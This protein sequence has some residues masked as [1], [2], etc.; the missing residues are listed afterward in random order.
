[1]TTFS[2]RGKIRGHGRSL[3]RR[4]RLSKLAL[5]SERISAAFWPAFTVTCLFLALAF[6]GLFELAGPLAHRM[7]LGAFGVFLLAALAYG[8]WRFRRPSQIEAMDRLDADHP[9]RPLATM[10]DSLVLHRSDT[11]NAETEAIWHAHQR[12]AQKAALTLEAAAPD[13]RLSRN[14]RWAMRLFAPALLLAAL[15]GANQ[16][17]RGH[18]M[19]AFSPAPLSPS[20]ATAAELEPM[21]E[22]WATPPAYT[23]HDTLYLTAESDG[24]PIYLAT[25]SEITVR[26]TQFDN[27]PVLDA[28]GLT[29][30]ADFTSLGGGLSEVV[31]ELNAS[32]A[33]RVFDGPKLMA[34]W[35]V[36]AI[37]DQVPVIETTSRPA[38]T[39]TRALEIEFSASDD[40]GVVSAWAEIQPVEADRGKGLDLEP[41][42]FALPLPISRDTRT[43]ADSIIEDLTEHPWAG[44]MVDLVLY[45]EDGA[46]QIGSTETIS[47]RLPA[48]YFSD[49]LAA[50][51]IEQRRDLALDFA[52][53][54]RVLDVIQAITKRPQA[55]F[56]DRHGPYMGT[57]MAVR[58]LANGIANETV[59]AVAPE[60]VDLLWE[61]ALSLEQGDISDALERLRNAEQA[62]R[63]A[64]ENGTDEEVAQ[65]IQEL[66][67]AMNEYIQELARQAQENPQAFQ[68]QQPQQ[69]G[70]QLSQQD[71][72]EMLNEMQ[73]QAE[74]GLRD[75]ARDML[76]ELSRMLENL[77]AGQ[78]QMQ[79][80]GQGQ[81]AMQELQEMIQRQRDLADR[82]FDELRQQRR[83]QQ[84][85]GQGNRA[86]QGQQEGQRPGEGQQGQAPGQGRQQGGAGQEGSLS[87][88]QEALRRALEDLARSL[89]G[90][91]GAQR[92]LGEAGDAMGSARDALGDGENADAVQDQM[93]ALDR[94]NEGAQALADQMQNGQGD[95][96]AQ[97]R[98]EQDG[99]GRDRAETDPFDRPLGS[100]GSTSGNHTKVPDRSALDRAREILDELRRRSAESFRPDY[101]LDYFDRLLD[102]F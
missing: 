79:Q 36:E 56:E 101:E 31:A 45:A 93:E 92:A 4:I 44:S 11:K 63:D 82:T 3:R 97:G 58:R 54:A 70:Q 60:I 78:P 95:V 27:Q 65:A 12:Q 13:L 55:I 18:L 42:T 14:D 15:V 71:L 21:V 48:R 39:L 98:G 96:G 17:W 32:G 26:T 7:F 85:Q 37:P 91:E 74:S 88:Q 46:G 50:A 25:G 35:H 29:D 67:E 6:M 102:Q 87:A 94:M 22:A 28:P 34:E 19:S 10:S 62:L 43:I 9:A 77:Q 90:G 49:P 69:Q 81:Q 84:G 20:I 24:E 76:S 38:P 52:Q 53:A 68:E 86:E 61:I 72:D 51:L 73:R 16:D 66:R 2:F 8:I 33:I 80:G 59:S 47:L 5:W 75:Q 57:R 64:L 41:I 1:M 89:P 100:Y 99:Q 30:V 40:Y 83:Q 23:G